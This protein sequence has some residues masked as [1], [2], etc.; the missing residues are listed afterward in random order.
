[1]GVAVKAWRLRQATRQ[2]LDH[3]DHERALVLASEAQQTHRTPRGDSLHLLSAWLT[4]VDS[5][6]QN[7]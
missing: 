3:G 5:R 4:D 7:P 1:M 2:A 6:R